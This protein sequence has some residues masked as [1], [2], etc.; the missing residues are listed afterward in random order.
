MELPGHVVRVA[1]A[2][3]DDRPQ[4]EAPDEHS[5]RKARNRHPG[6]QLEF[7][8][9]LGGGTAVGAESGQVATAEHRNESTESGYRHESFQ[10]AGHRGPHERDISQ[11]LRAG[12]KLATLPNRVEL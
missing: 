12:A 11:G 2:V 8:L 1:A 4:D 6:P 3:G 5:D 9:A 7:R 10:P